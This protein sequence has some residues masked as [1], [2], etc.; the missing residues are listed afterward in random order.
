MRRVSSCLGTILFLFF[1]LSRAVF[2]TPETSASTPQTVRSGGKAMHGNPP[3][4]SG[5]QK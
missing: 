4:F 1:L 2:A 5:A 3:I